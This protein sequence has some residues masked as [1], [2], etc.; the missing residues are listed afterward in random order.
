MFHLCCNLTN[1]EL[2]ECNTQDVTLDVKGKD[3][4][5]VIANLSRFIEAVN[6]GFEER[7]D[8]DDM[9]RQKARVYRLFLETEDIYKFRVG[10]KIRFNFTNMYE[11]VPF[12]KNLKP[13]EY[14]SS[15]KDIEDLE[16]HQITKFGGLNGH[17]EALLISYN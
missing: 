14:N 6:Q 12:N 1:F 9:G 2:Y 10:Q 13:Y 15:L 11:D 4:D 5:K 16:I 8:L 17:Y 7:G 3:Q